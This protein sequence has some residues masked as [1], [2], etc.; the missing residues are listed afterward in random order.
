MTASRIV[1]LAGGLKV[2]AKALRFF[3]LAICQR[4]SGLSVADHHANQNTTSTRAVRSPKRNRGSQLKYQASR[5]GR[6][7]RVDAQIVT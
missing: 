1:S 5:D 7:G 2:A 6:R 3:F 4:G